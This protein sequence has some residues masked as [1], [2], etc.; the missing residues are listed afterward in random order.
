MQCRGNGQCAGE[1]Q[2]MHAPVQPLASAAIFLV[3]EARHLLHKDL[4]VRNVTN[5]DSRQAYWALLKMTCMGTG[6]HWT[7]T[8]LTESN[9]DLVLSPSGRWS[10]RASPTICSLLSWE[11]VQG[12]PTLLQDL[13]TKSSFPNLQKRKTNAPPYHATSQI[14]PNIH[15]ALHCVLWEVS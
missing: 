2:I 3:T 10:C 5:F 7:A 13:I 12:V 6:N 14:P 8:A 9:S 15:K 11:G 4:T 1:E